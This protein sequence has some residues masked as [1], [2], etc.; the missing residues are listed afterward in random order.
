VDEEY[1]C[2]LFT[3]EASHEDRTVRRFIHSPFLPSSFPYL[4]LISSVLFVLWPSVSHVTV[5]P[6]FRSTCRFEL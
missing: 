2:E 6:I 1:S 4:G 3:A 5:L